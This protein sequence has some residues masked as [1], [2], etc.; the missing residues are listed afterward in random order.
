MTTLFGRTPQDSYPELLTLDNSGQG[1]DSTLR[2]VQDGNGVSSPLKLSTTK[3]AIQGNQLPTSAGSAGQFLR[4]STTAN[5]L[6]WFTPVVG[7]L[8]TQNASTVAITG[9][10][11]TGMPTP[12]N[13][14]DIATKAYADSA[15][16]GSSSSFSTGMIK[17]SAVNPGS[18]WLPAN[19][20]VYL[21]SAYPTLGAMLGPAS[22]VPNS[23]TTLAPFAIPTYFTIVDMFASS[24][25]VLIAAGRTT[26]NV[27]VIGRTTDGSTWTQ[28][29]VPAL[30]GT[31]TAAACVNNLFIVGLSTGAVVTSTD[32]TTWTS[33]SLGMAGTQYAIA[34]GNGKY[35]IAGS[36]SQIATSTDGINWSL[37][38]YAS[39]ATSSTV[40]AAAYGNG[41]F[42]VGLSNGRVYSSPD[43]ITWT[44]RNS[45]L[46][47]SGFS[48]HGITYG[49]NRFYAQGLPTATTY[50][51]GYSLDGITWT[52][53]TTPFNTGTGDEL[54]ANSF[55]GVFF[56]Y[57]RISSTAS[58]GYTQNGSTWVTFN[59]NLIATAMGNFNGRIITTSGTTMQFIN[60]YTTNPYLQFNTPAMPAL[61]GLTAYIKS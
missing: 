15:S 57:S 18:A 28:C 26:G 39:T 32:G 44:L 16:S 6:E 33:L 3:V 25:T 34:Y 9:G 8:G 51:A 19:N 36:S 42:V 10:S 1:F 11:I 40:K 17:Y 21:Q 27:L 46:F 4:V 23:T 38:A 58:Y 49:N 2:A 14:T 61:T 53:A 12:A 43:T 7:T 47:P 56:Q 48:A 30:T 35:L 29:T 41:M 55:C 22:Y 20:T 59:A 31:V 45:T 37:A 5:L 24:N 50:S 60:T 13:A 52:S 54:I